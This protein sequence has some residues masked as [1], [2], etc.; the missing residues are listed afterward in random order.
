MFS[1]NI[2]RGT[3]TCRCC[4]YPL[5]DA[6]L[7]LGLQ[8]ISNSLLTYEKDRKLQQYPLEFRICS[9]CQLG[10]IGEYEKPEEIFQEYTYLSST[11]TS[12]LNHAKSYVNTVKS[13][14]N[15]NP[16]DLIIEIASNDGYLLQYFLQE[17]YQVLGIEPA[18]NVANLAIAKGI[19]TQVSFFGKEVALDLV[20]KKK[21]PKLV[22]CNNVLAHVPDINDFMEGL[23]ILVNNGAMLSVE[24][25]SMLI[26]LEKNLFDTI[27]HE[28]FSYLNVI[29]IEYLTKKFGLVL[30]DVDFLN[31]HGGSYRYWIGNSGV[32]KKP[33][34][35]FYLKK[36]EDFMFQSN[37]VQEAFRNNSKTTIKCFRDWCLSQK[38]LPIGFGAAAKATVLLNA[39][40]I[41]A[42][43][44]AVI[45]D[46]SLL[47]QKKLVPGV[48]VPIS[49]PIEVFSKYDGNLVIFPW[50]LSREITSEIKSKYPEFKREIWTALPSLRRI[51]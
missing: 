6:V 3:V 12:W 7:S 42:Q 21:N 20:R 17:K 23:A 16:G 48:N 28:H 14:Y 37:H 26:L 36:E 25:P 47:K 33:S 8:P 9:K 10:Q 19:P 13:S 41:S 30:Y 46:N 15:L 27:Y 5:N 38:S 44:F 1:E 22:V 39:A 2:G 32:K 31:S 24:A 11:S 40:K 45:A 35:E 29:S 34:V 43:E 49:S 18:R 4:S 51:L 50:N